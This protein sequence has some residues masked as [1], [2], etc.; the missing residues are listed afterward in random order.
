TRCIDACPTKA[1]VA[2]RIVDARKCISYQTIELKGKL[3]NNLT[4]QFEN[5]VFGCDICQD[6]CPWNLKSQ[7]HSEPKFKPHPKLL[8]LTKD[9]WYE[10]GKPLFNELFKNSAV[11]RTGFKGLKRNLDFLQ[12]NK[13]E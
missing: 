4:G 7:S 3:D 12:I 11:K 1:I 5:R 2:D 6:V 9:E 10:M 13:D 8:D